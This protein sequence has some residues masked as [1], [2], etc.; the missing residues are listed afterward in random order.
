M[1]LEGELLVVDS[2][3]ADS[4]VVDL[5]F[6]KPWVVYHLRTGESSLR[7][8]FRS[9]DEQGWRNEKEA[10]RYQRNEGKWW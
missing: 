10:V 2:V 7:A 1:D 6:V 4:V 8:T 3:V 5:E 9:K